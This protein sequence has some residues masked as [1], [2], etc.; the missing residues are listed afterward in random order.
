MKRLNLTAAITLIAFAGCV[1]LA[2][3]NY[4]PKPH[5][6]CRSGYVAKTVKVRKHERKHGRLVW[7]RVNERV[8]V[9]KAVTVTP[10]VEPKTTSLAVHLDPNYTVNPNNPLD[11]TY[12]YSASATIGTAPDPSLP[13]GVL[14]FFS[15]GLLECSTTVGGDIDGG[16]CEVTYSDYGD[17][18]TNVIY[19]SGT[20]SVTTGPETVT[21]PA[22][23]TPALALAAPPPPPLLSTTTTVTVTGGVSNG[24]SPD[25]CTT[26][27]VG[28]T[29]SSSGKFPLW[30]YAIIYQCVYTITVNTTDQNGNAIT[31]GLSDTYCALVAGTCKFT[32]SQGLY[33]PAFAGGDPSE[34]T[35]PTPPSDCTGQTETVMGSFAGSTTDAPSTSTPVSV[36]AFG[37]CAPTNP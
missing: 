22:P 34:Y 9:K 14:E 3:A 15:D 10:V 2:H 21:I 20:N 4:I 27:N 37:E 25:T 17:H 24:T 8:C 29:L 13:N 18:T 11:L 30:A 6:A 31:T 23:P 26:T 5:H 32:D 1:T 7:V 12:S 36:S 33:G 19:D 35:P 16:T 28:I